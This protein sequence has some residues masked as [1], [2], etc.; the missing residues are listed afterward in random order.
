MIALDTK[1]RLSEHFTLG[2]MI[3]NS[4]GYDNLP[5]PEEL[6]SL[7]RLCNTILEPLRKAY[8]PIVVS[9]GY[10]C[11]KLNEAV[12]GQPTSYHR[13]G[14]AADLV[15]QKITARELLNHVRVMPTVPFDKAIAETDRDQD[16]K[17]VNWLHIQAAPIGT[18]PR[19]LMFTS[20]RNGSGKMEY[21]QVDWEHPE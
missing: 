6:V 21:T 7:T 5:D 15:P 1:T 4:H 20:K 10:R 3:A 12:G 11:A 17:E 16:G 2:E 19:R 18:P 9:S 14:L 13:M 8:G